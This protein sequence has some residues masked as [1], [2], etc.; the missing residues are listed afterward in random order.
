MLANI[1]KILGLGHTTTNL[2]FSVIIF[3]LLLLFRDIQTKKINKEQHLNET[4][5][6]F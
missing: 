4:Q 5:I 2:R 3:Y 6:L 1:R